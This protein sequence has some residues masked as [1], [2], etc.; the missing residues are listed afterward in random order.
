MMILLIWTT[1]MPPSLCRF[2]LSQMKIRY[3]KRLVS[4]LVCPVFSRM[5]NTHI[6]LLAKMHIAGIIHGDL[7]YS[8]HV[9]VYAFRS[10]IQSSGTTLTK[11]QALR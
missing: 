7:I 10:S 5:H 4:L 1:S 6:L 8:L 3:K 11:H 9:N 2:D